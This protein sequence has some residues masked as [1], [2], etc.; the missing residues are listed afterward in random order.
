M[1]ALPSQALLSSATRAMDQLQ[2]LLRQRREAGEPVA[3][4]NAFEQEVHRLCVAAEREALGHELARC[5]LDVP[6]IEVAGAR[7]HRVLRCATTSQSAAGP[8]RVERSLYR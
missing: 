5:D 7:C 3:D 8:V 2:A 6:T 1:Q 4:F